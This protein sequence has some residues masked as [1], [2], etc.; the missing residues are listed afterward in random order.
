MSRPASTAQ[1]A[2]ALAAFAS[3]IVLPAQAADTWSQLDV[4]GRTRPSLVH[5]PPTDGTAKP[6]P[7]VILFHGGGGSAE[8]AAR[9]SAMS[10]TADRE[11]FIVV[12][13]S[14]SS[15]FKGR[16]LT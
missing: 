10:A 15:A 13:P 6:L 2:A 11:K 7:L 12:Y 1:V 9:Q 16:L 3:A 14:G 4:G 5:T 8:G